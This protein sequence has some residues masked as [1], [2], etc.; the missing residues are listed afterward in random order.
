MISKMVTLK[1]GQWWYGEQRDGKT[2]VIKYTVVDPNH[3]AASEREM[4]PR[5][6]EIAVFV[7]NFLVDAK[8]SWQMEEDDLERILLAYAKVYI[9]DRILEG[10]CLDDREEIPLS[11]KNAPQP[12]YDPTDVDV[13]YGI[14]FEVG[15]NSVD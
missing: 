10:G 12:R 2:L 6:K 15:A 9:E 7:S 14:P 1:S 11:T 8:A 5:V 4:Q 3:R 13:R